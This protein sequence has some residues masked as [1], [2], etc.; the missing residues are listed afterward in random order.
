[1]IRYDLRCSQAHEFDGWFQDSAGYDRLAGARLVECPACGDTAV[2]KRLMAPALRTSPEDR[3]PPAESAAPA[4]APAAP[5]PPP[6]IGGR[7]PPQMMAALQRMRAEVEARCDYVG[8]D[9]AEEARRIHRGESERTAI[10]GEATEADAEA[11]QDE[12]IEVGRIPWVPR[13][14]G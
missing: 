3:R 4:A 5:A 12:G 13:A 10:Y 14:D 1:M 8:R 6:A 7:L 11:L 9:F 2:T